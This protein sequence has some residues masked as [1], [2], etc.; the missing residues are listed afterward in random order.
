MEATFRWTLVTATAPIAW[1]TTYFVT[2]Q[3]LPPGYPLYGAAVRAL[4]AGLL[5]LLLSGRLPHGSWWWKSLVLG[6][7]NMS[8]FFALVY[9]A[10]QLLPTSV[11]STI[12]A[13]SPVVM[14]LLAWSMLSERPRIAH[15][16]GAGVGI[17]GVCL[18][19]FTGASAVDALGVLASVAAMVMS[20]FGYVLAKRW[21]TGAG[22]L[23]SASWQLIAGGLVLLPFAVALEGPPPALDAP[24]VLGFAY[25]TVVATA[26]AF[27]AWFSG[28]R[29]LPAATVGLVG[30]LNPV[31]GVLLGT[32]IAAEALTARQLCG[33]A[34]VLLG[35]L[36]GQ[37][38][39]ARL[40]ALLRDRKRP[41]GTGGGRGRRQ[42]TWTRGRRAVSC[43]AWR[44][45]SRVSGGI[46]PPPKTR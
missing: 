28:L 23:S 13:M 1:G 36:L 7:L 20:S 24:A 21:T 19:L 14:M 42:P 12:M 35:I 8:A 38:A 33:L 18:M 46:S 45:T 43:S 25:V 15:L 32:T 44:S 6:T 27:A 4:P 34:L 31:T 37:P 22:A 9:L 30:L 2:Q 17:A 39:A 3:F 41:S 11:A 26:L 5:L 40:A 29:H 16:A 10:A